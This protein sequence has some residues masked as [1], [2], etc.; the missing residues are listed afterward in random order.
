MCR[1]AQTTFDAV[2]SSELRALRRA[3]EPVYDDLERHAGTRAAIEAIERL[4]QDVGAPPAELPKCDR[5]ERP[6][7]DD[8]SALDGVW[9]MD[10][11]RSAARPD[12]LEEN[13]AVGST[14]SIAAGSR[15]RRRI[16]TRTRAPGS[17]ARSR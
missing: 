11:D 4:K 12:Y 15:S 10:T 2:S 9:R 7:G 6:A 17:T 5:A 16:R 3:V 8:K 14:S 13:W 1:K